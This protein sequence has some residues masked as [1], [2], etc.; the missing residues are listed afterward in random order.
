MM[1]RDELLDRNRMIQQIH[2]GTET[3]LDPSGEPITYMAVVASLEEVRA[4]GLDPD[5]IPNVIVVDD[6]GRRYSLG[7]WERDGIAD[8]MEG[9]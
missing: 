3:Y 9:M 6:E 4:A 2:D 8:E 1:T 5:D 7:A